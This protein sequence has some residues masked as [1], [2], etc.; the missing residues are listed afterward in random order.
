MH[1]LVA[2]D[3]PEIRKLF[4]IW[5]DHAGHTVHLVENGAEAVA[6]GRA[7]AFDAVILDLEMP[8]MNGWDALQ[9]IRDLPH[10]QWLPI[11]VISGV[12]D[13]T[14]MRPAILKGAD[15]VFMKPLEPEHIVWTMEKLVSRCHVTETEPS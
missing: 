10:G 3:L 4:S 13:H 8:V 5:F 14:D 11:A 1:F 12:F 2:D 6:A 9:Q 15:V 7:Q